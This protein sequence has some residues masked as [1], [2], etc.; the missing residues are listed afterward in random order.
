MSESQRRRD[1]QTVHARSKKKR[2]EKKKKEWRSSPASS[3]TSALVARLNSRERRV[4][5]HELFALAK[6]ARA[7]DA[8]LLAAIPASSMAGVA[9]VERTAMA[10]YKATEPWRGK[11]AEM[12]QPHAVDEISD[13]T[14]IS[15]MFGC[16]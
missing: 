3:E 15:S 13:R 12:L 16:N 2:E 9:A 11:S 1:R 7:A 6:S 5:N 8:A 10:G 4:L 14:Q